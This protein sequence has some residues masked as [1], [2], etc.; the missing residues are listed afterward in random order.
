MKKQ[1]Y[2]VILSIILTLGVVGLIIIASPGDMGSQNQEAGTAGQET[3]SPSNNYISQIKGTIRKAY[4]AGTFYPKE[5][6]T[7][8]SELEKYL[9][10]VEKLPSDNKL[11]M[12]VLPHA[13]IQYSGLTDAWGAKQLSGEKYSKVIILGVSHKYSY[14]HAAI[15]AEGAWETPLGTIQI[16]SETGTK[17][18]SQKNNVIIDEAKHIDD[19]NLEIPLLFIQKV[20]SDFKI[21]PIM[22]G[23]QS[24]DV[25]DYLAFKIASI[26]DDETL[27]VIST[28]LSH[29]PNWEDAEKAD[30]RVIDAIVTGKQSEFE[31]A[32][33][34]NAQ[35]KYAGLSTSACGFN[36]VKVGLRV[37]EILDFE[38]VKEL[39]STNSGDVTGEKDSVVGY[40]SIAFWS[41]DN[42]PIISLD[43]RAKK[44]ALK[45]ARSTLE[46]Y[47]K[48]N[49]IEEDYTPFSADLLQPIGAFVTLT[50]KEELRGCIGSFEPEDPVYKVIQ[51][52]VISAATKD[53]RFQSVTKEEL[54]EINIEISTMSPQKLIKNWQDIEIGKHGVRIILNGKSGT[55][56]PQVATDNNWNLT[57]FLETICW[58]KMGL[59]DKECYKNASAKIF[60]YETDIFSEDKLNEK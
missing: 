18:L 31:R 59:Q 5:P 22:L 6:A 11:R 60:T 50:N 23:N 47:Y 36:A 52:V 26:I 57:T 21:I 42:I 17:L 55:L 3:P 45:L 43:E 49:A 38:E 51:S 29:Y 33:K 48:G 37:A 25:V 35:H 12:L 54:P 24:E 16:D 53:K 20:L 4:A 13:G 14:S 19:H 28:D 46:A 10:K 40:T 56:L 2:L 9:G 1:Y 7:L 44:E 41:D 30:R 8:N 27:L 15:F 32:V 34:V 58:Q 39:H